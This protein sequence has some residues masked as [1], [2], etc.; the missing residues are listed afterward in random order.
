MIDGKTVEFSTAV[1]KPF[2]DENGRTQ[3][4]LRAAM[5]A[6]GAKV[7]WDGEVRT[8]VVTK[9]YVTVRVPIGA[10]FVW[11]NGEKKTNDTA[12]VDRQ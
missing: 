12:A 1:G 11:I 9:G 10:E 3:V 5:E 8:A 2:I 6:M 7:D 4:P